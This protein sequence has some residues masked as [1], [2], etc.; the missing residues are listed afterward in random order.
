MR[1]TRARASGIW[2]K[3]IN[4]EKKT[5]YVLISKVGECTFI[6]GVASDEEKAKK[7]VE[8]SSRAYKSSGA[9]Y[10]YGDYEID[11]PYA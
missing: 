7:W 9:D 8:R 1:I 10:F 6:H 11:D 4:M 5:V 3:E 2:G